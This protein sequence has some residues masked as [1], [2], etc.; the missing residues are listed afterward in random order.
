MG[1]C[2]WIVDWED[3]DDNGYKD[4]AQLD[5]EIS[6]EMTCSEYAFGSISLSCG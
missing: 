6:A 4:M 1:V 2:I 3:A 5:D